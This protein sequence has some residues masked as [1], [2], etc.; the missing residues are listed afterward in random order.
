[1]ISPFA[2]LI[3]FDLGF[4]ILKFIY[5]AEQDKEPFLKAPN[6]IHI[7]IYFNATALLCGILQLNERLKKWDISLHRTLGWIYFCCTNIGAIAAI[8]FATSRTYGDDNGF[9]GSVSFLFMALASVIPCNTGVYYI[10]I[11]NKP[12]KHRDWMLRSFA[13]MF[14][15]SFLFRV[16]SRLYLPLAPKF[17]TAWISLIWMSWVIPLWIIEQYISYSSRLSSKNKIN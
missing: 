5:T 7:H 1:L 13:S 17:Y 15:A 10:V 11:E 6:S 2:F 4:Y 16:L 3:S 8:I 9:A 14:G 12:N